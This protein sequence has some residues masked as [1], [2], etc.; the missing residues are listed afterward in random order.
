MK[1]AIEYL[2]TVRDICRKGDCNGRC[3]LNPDRENNRCPWR[4]E[5]YPAGWTDGHILGMI[6][7]AEQAKRGQP[8]E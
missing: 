2:R 4:S 1:G 8:D 3:P 7:A 5:N 6:N